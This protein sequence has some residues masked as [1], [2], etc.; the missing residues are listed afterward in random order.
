[1]DPQGVV[2]GAGGLATIEKTRCEP[3][4]GGLVA[5]DGPSGAGKTTV[6]GVLSDRLASAG[7]AVLQVAQPSQS[8]LGRLARGGTYDY[9]GPA[10]SCLVAADRYD[11]LRRVLEPALA[12]GRVVVCDRYVASALVLDRLDGL[13]RSFVWNLYRYIHWPDLWVFLTADAQ[14]RLARTAARGRY[15]RFH[16]HD[17][18]TAAEEAR[19]YRKAHP[20]LARRGHRT[21]AIDT[22][23]DAAEAVAERLVDQIRSIVGC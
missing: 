10:L 13:D 18:A 1:M 2:R 6:C 17:L 15:S 3:A 20:E 5:V 14:V 23:T 19:L 8:P 4:A 21:V 16:D 12:A 11:Q 9:R 22:T 7:E